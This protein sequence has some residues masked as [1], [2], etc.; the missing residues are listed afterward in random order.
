MHTLLIF[1]CLWARYGSDL[2]QNTLALQVIHVTNGDA[3]T[4]AHPLMAEPYAH[5]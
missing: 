5:M 3:N 2:T 1:P 4:T